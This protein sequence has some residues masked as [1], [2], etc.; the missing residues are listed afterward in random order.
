MNRELYNIL[1]NGNYFTHII[2]KI[3][4]KDI[5]VKL[6]S[7]FSL[8]CLYSKDSLREMGINVEGRVAGNIRI[9]K[10]SNVSL[11]D[12]AGFNLQRKMLSPKFSTFFPISTEDIIFL[13]DNSIEFYK[14]AKRHDFDFHEIVV[15]N[16]VPFDYIFGLVIPNIEQVKE[17]VSKLLKQYNI[18]LCVYDYEGNMLDLNKKA[19]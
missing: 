14:G 17:I 6:E 4:D 1:I 8:G 12:P 5:F 7:I 10:D 15:K 9:T 19:R 16:K 3:Y 18:D 11:F 13:V 2:G